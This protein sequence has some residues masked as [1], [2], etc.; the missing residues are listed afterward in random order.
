MAGAPWRNLEAL[1]SALPRR[2]SLHLY[3]R[4]TVGHMRTLGSSLGVRPPWEY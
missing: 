4:H 2:F 1:P 3:V